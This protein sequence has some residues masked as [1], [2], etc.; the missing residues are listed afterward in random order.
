MLHKIIRRS[1]N[2]PSDLPSEKERKKTDENTFSHRIFNLRTCGSRLFFNSNSS[3]KKLVLTARFSP[4]RSN[5]YSN[6]RSY[7]HE[8]KYNAFSQVEK[9]T[10]LSSE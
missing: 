7:E 6:K 9:K 5:E 3:F 2:P 4:V 8:V 1:N 10:I